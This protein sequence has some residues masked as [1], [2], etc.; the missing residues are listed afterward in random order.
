[1]IADVRI[2]DMLRCFLTQE[3][4]HPPG[5]IILTFDDSLVPIAFIQSHLKEW[6]GELPANR[7]RT[8][9]QPKVMDAI[10]RS[11]LGHSPGGPGSLRQIGDRF[12]IKGAHIEVIHKSGR[13]S[14]HISTITEFFTGRTIRLNAEYIA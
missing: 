6:V 4:N 3:F 12:E 10:K 11:G 5:D 9:S 8:V 13:R 1:M 2:Q 14:D 7:T